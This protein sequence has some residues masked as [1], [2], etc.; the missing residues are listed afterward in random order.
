MP[1]TLNSA[2]TAYDLAAARTRLGLSQAALAATLG[3]SPSQIWRI[4]K[5]KEANR[6]MI[7]AMYGVEMHQGKKA[8]N[9]ISKAGLNQEGGHV[10]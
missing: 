4:E 5:A 3:V 2:I 8:A 1:K 6:L 9:E 10:L 7:W